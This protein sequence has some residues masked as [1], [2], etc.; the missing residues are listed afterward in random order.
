M[1]TVIGNPPFEL[2]MSAGCTKDALIFTKSSPGPIDGS[3]TSCT[4]SVVDEP[5]LLTLSAFIGCFAVCR[6]IVVYFP[7]KILQENRLFLQ[8]VL[9]WTFKQR[10]EYEYSSRWMKLTLPYNQVVLRCG[11]EAGA[12][13]VYQ[14]LLTSKLTKAL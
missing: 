7:C 3:A 6:D 12:D 13:I 2:R 14:I 11:S 9:P 1:H 10:V 5:S 8:R 4:P